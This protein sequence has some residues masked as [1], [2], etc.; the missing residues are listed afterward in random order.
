MLKKRAEEIRILK[1]HPKMKEKLFVYGTLK[2]PKIQQRVIG[3]ALT[4]IPAT[5]KGYKNS[6]IKIEEKSYSVFFPGENKSVR[7]LI[8]SI[9][10][11]ELKFIDNYETNAYQR[12]K[13]FLDNGEKMWVFAK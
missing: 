12:K 11:K 4:G 9:T 2:N 1:I 7:G 6:K 3:R 13:A 5:L 8:L 10:E